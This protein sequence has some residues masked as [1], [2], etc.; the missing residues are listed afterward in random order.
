MK[1]VL[2]IIHD[3]DAYDIMDMLRDRGYSA[4]KLA[5]TGGFLRSGN[6][7]LISGVDEQRVDELIGII[8]SKG[9][10]RKQVMAVNPPGAG[11]GEGYVPFPVEVSVGGATIF[12]MDVEQFRKV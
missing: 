6:T 11:T 8:E 5:S 7:T 10:S 9:K 1:L 12:V 3:D 2:A 4:T